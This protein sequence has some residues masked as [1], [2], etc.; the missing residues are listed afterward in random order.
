[1]TYILKTDLE[2]L[3]DPQLLDRQ[4]RAYFDYLETI[5]SSLSPTAYE[6][7]AAAW[8]YDHEDHRCPHDGWVEKLEIT[9]RATGPRDEVRSIDTNL[10]LLGAYHDGSLELGY[11]DVAEYSLAIVAHSPSDRPRIGHGDWLRD[12]ITL[13]G[14]SLVRH[15]IEFSTEA[16][17]VII[18]RD[19]TWNWRPR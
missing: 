4:F 17:W 5:R 8:H 11:I 1:M 10:R 6:F 3:R 16:S 19:L 2:Q 9:E 18:C 15:E 7:A 14:G 13:T 12:E